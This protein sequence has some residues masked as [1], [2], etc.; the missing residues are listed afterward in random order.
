MTS[1]VPLAVIGGGCE[2]A[3]VGGWAGVLVDPEGDLVEMLRGDEFADV[4]DGGDG[5]AGGVV[6]G[7]AAGVDAGEIVC[8]GDGFGP[9]EEVGGLVVVEAAA[10]FLIE[11]EDGVGGEVF[12]LGGGD[13]CGGV[14]VLRASAGVV[15]G[16]WRGRFRRRVWPLARTRKPKLLRRRMSRLPSQVLVRSPGGLVSQ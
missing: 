12:A 2:G 11:K 15:P 13:G 8:V 9:G 14:F 16:V 10:F 5:F 3:A 4:L 7:L 6:D 1:G